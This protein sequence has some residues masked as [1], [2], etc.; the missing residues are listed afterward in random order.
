MLSLIRREWK[1][2]EKSDNVEKS[3]LGGGGRRVGIKSHL[4]IGR[5]E[6]EGG[7]R[8]S[9]FLDRLNPKDTRKGCRHPHPVPRPF[10]N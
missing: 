3:N 8:S 2:W 6:E 7:P 10:T 5:E 1:R 9:D 4:F